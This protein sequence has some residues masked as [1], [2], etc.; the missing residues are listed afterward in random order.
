MLSFPFLAPTTGHT[1]VPSDRV[2]QDTEAQ[3]TPEPEAEKG[4]GHSPLLRRLLR[5][6]SQ[7]APTLTGTRETLREV[8]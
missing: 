1:A 7:D 4:G 2:R 5:V 6:N 3:F 8:K